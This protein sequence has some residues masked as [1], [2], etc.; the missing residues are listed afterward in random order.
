MDPTGSSHGDKPCQAQQAVDAF[1]QGYGVSVEHGGSSAHYSSTGGHIQ[2]LPR[3]AFAGTDTSSAT[4]SYYS[5]F[6]MNW[7]R[8]P[9]AKIVAAVSCVNGL[10]IAHTVWKNILQNLARRSFALNQ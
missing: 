9:G 5:T 1:V 2:T 4:E 6:N 3:G 10:G 7:C 8:G